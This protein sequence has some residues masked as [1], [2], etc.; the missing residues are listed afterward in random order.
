MSR[1]FQ[2][3]GPSGRGARLDFVAARKLANAECGLQAPEMRTAAARRRQIYELTRPGNFL[4]YCQN[5]QSGKACVRLREVTLAAA[6]FCAG[7]DWWNFGLCATIPREPRQAR[8][9]ATVTG[10][11]RVPRNTRS[12][13][14]R[15]RRQARQVK[16][17]PGAKSSADPSFVRATGP[18]VGVKLGVREN[19]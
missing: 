19:R 10:Q 9:G 13:S 12:S 1:H 16:S 5:F 15:G 18:G 17:R 6:F 14:Y 3:C 8:K 2:V 7:G 11:S 4:K